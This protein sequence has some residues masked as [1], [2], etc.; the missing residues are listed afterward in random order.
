MDIVRGKN[1]KAV[2]N[3]NNGLMC[4]RLRKSQT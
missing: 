1:K 4:E 2:K 3:E